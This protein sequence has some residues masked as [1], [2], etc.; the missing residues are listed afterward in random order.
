M[1]QVVKVAQP[2][3]EKPRPIDRPASIIPPPREASPVAAKDQSAKMLGSLRLIGETARDDGSVERIFA[4]PFGKANMVVLYS[5]AGAIEQVAAHSNE[6]MYPAAEL[7]PEWEHT[8]ARKRR[9]SGKFTTDD[10]GSDLL[11]AKRAV[12][13]RARERMLLRK[14]LS[15]LPPGSPESSAAV[16]RMQTITK[17]AVERY[18]G[19]F[20]AG[21]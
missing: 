6:F 11:A 19:V 18:G 9:E 4:L 7:I 17:E 5:A 21:I 1:P 13:E 15:A 20:A 2:P 14:L 10:E 3:S 16:E 12:V 8:L